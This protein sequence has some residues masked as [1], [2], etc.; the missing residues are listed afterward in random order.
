MS[1]HLFGLQVHTQPGSASQRPLA[2]GALP[3]LDHCL[4]VHFNNV[5]PI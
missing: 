2:E 3:W 4:M 5:P 1:M